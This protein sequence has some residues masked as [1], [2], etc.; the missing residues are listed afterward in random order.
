MFLLIF[1]Y[2]HNIKKYPKNSPG[3]FKADM[4][5]SAY[6]GDCFVVLVQDSWEVDHAL[7][8]IIRLLFY[9][10]WVLESKDDAIVK[11]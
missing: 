9:K 5:I 11:L 6:D 2:D 7:S 10:F 1:T 3:S 8:F 4:T